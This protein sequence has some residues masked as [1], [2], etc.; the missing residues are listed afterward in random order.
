M[1][2]LTP[3]SNV[4]TLRYCRSSHT[5]T[6]PAD[7]MDCGVGC[8]PSF[9]SGSFPCQMGSDTFLSS[10]VLVIRQARC[11]YRLAMAPICG[12]TTESVTGGK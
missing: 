2:N 4:Y 7:N 10:V 11:G 8:R 5:L 1:L 3:E 12:V 6:V 9:P